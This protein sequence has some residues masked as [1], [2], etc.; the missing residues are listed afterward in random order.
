MP[1]D[2]KKRKQKSSKAAGQASAPTKVR[3]MI[4]LSED[5]SRQLDHHRAATG[6]EPSAAIEDLIGR[7]LPRYSLRVLDRRAGEGEGPPPG[8]SEG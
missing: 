2:M 3:K 5:A 7:H 8:E 1:Q 6:Q 4:S